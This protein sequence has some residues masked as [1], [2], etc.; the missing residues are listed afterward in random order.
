MKNKPIV[1][2]IVPARGGSK[3]IYRKNIR[4]LSGKPLLSYTA[5]AGLK[6]KFIDRIIL[7]TD[8]HEIASVGEVYGLEVPFLRP[9]RFATDSTP[10]LPVI[11]HAVKY[12][13][14]KEGFTPDYIIL[15][16]PTSPFRTTT[17]IDEALERLINSK[18][19]SIVSVVAVPH[20]FNPYSVM[21]LKGEYLSPYLEYDEKLNLRQKKPVFFARNGAAIY[22]FTFNCLISLNSI[23]G[24][25]IL[26]YFMNKEDSLDID[27]AFDWKI[28][29]FLMIEKNKRKQTSV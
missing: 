19:D 6:S 15:L 3:G 29:E 4:K 25:T 14:S 24:D 11:L 22:A 8:D 23:Y 27:D 18:A 28:A 20:C 7:S 16:Q 21:Q 13:E 1:L 2:G 12:L 10:A 26:P 17:H 5:E 9:A